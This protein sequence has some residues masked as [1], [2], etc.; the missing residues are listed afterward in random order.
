MYNAPNFRISHLGYRLERK[1][2][3]IGAKE[4]P[5][6][7]DFQVS[8][9]HGASSLRDAFMASANLGIGAAGRRRAGALPVLD[10]GRQ[11][12]DLP[13]HRR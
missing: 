7:F 2:L 4:M 11:L 5:A 9:N 1:A 10:Q 6:W 13:V 12:D 8:R 3:R